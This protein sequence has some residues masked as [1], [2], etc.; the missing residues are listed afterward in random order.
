M[1]YMFCRLQLDE[2]VRRARLPVE[3]YGDLRI[4]RNSDSIDLDDSLQARYFS[5]FRIHS[6]VP[7]RRSSLMLVVIR[8][9]DRGYPF[10]DLSSL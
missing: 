7:A 8:V 3:D 1:R 2:L 4:P 10:Q 9:R 6:P 5:F